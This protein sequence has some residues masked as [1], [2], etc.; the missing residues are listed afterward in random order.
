MQVPT[1]SRELDALEEAD[2]QELR[3]WVMNPNSELKS[4]A[5]KTLISKRQGELQGLME[6]SQAQVAA[7]FELGLAMSQRQQEEQS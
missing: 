7:L 3:R 4:E 1:W 2:D 6:Q 5:V